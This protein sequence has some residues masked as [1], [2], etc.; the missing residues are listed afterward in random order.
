LPADARFCPACGG[1]LARTCARCGTANG[2]DH[3]FCKACGSA[4]GETPAPDAGAALTSRVSLEGERKQITVLFAD[5]KGSMELLASRDPEDARAVLDPVLEGMI[6][7]VRRYGGTVNQVMGDGVMALFGAPLAVEDHAVRAC[8]AALAMQDAVRRLAEARRSAGL[9]PPAIRVGL[10]S[11]EVLVRS[12]GSDV[13]VDYTAVGETTHLAARMEQTATPDAILL[14]QATY[15]LAEGFVDAKPLGLVGI[16]GLAEPVET[17]QLLGAHGVRTRLEARG[18]ALSRF[19]GREA[20]T[21]QAVRALAA[22]AAGRG[23]IVAVV[24]EPGVGKSRICHE[25]ARG[26]AGRGQRVVES[27]CLSYGTQTA[28]LPMAGLLET[29][30]DLDPRGE[31]GTRRAQAVERL[32]AID[33]ALGAAPAPILVLLG[34]PTSDAA[35]AA[36][37]PPLRRQQTLDALRQLILQ[38]ARSRPLIVVL[39]D[40][41]WV[42]AETQALLDALVDRMAAVPLALL[43]NY[44][45][46]YRHG[47]SG[48]S[49]YAQLRLDPLP[50]D[51][52]GALLE[53]LLGRDPSLAPLASLLRERTGGNPLFLE[54]SVRSLVETGALRGTAGDYR[55][56]RP[57]PS[58]E[59]PASVQ[60][61]LAARIDR[62]APQDK[63][64]LQCAAAIGYEV[65]L[66]LLRAIAGV[67]ET[68]LRDGLARLQAGELVY[69]TR[70][71]PDVEYTF[72]HALTHDVAYGSLLREQRRTLHA[73]IA[74]ALEAGAAEEH[75]AALAHHAGLGEDWPR[76]ARWARVAADQAAALCADAESV[77]LYEQALTAL[78]RLPETAETARAGLDVRFAL[79]APLWRAGRLDRLAPLFREVESLATRHGQTDRLDAVAA[80]LTQ[81]YWASGDYRK[82]IEYGERSLAL[83]ER[84]DDLALRASTHF[85]LGHSWRSMGRLPDGRA[86]YARVYALLEGRETERCG[87]SGLPFSGSCAY[88]AWSALELGDGAEALELI[89]R[90]ARVADR[91]GHLYSQIVI[92]IYRAWVLMLLGRADEARPVAEAALA[93]CRER[94]FAGQTMIALMALG[95]TLG[96]LGRAAEGVPLVEECI[97]LQQRANAQSDRGLMLCCLARLRLASGDLDGAQRAL[98]EGR[99]FVESNPEESY[100]AWQDWVRGQLAA[101][102]GDRAGAVALWRR[103]IAD[104]E[105]LGLALLRAHCRLSLGLAHRDAGDKDAAR[106]ELTQA[107]TAF[108]TIG[109]APRA[110][111]ADTALRGL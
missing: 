76:A 84:R 59:V 96:E 72:K 50:P 108:R 85:Y 21:A 20:E 34:L 49:Y 73:T 66:P 24:G 17:W 71:Y 19:V 37:D 12:I 94:N 78:A 33:P 11:G 82:S 22:A 9:P 8:Y 88:D 18:S 103:A 101:A 107:A 90:G 31:A 105:R 7:A 36:L 89:E 102:R 28:Y 81:F 4:L 16:K 26:A 64:L 54:E 32:R 86:H 42:D 67:D 3:R 38:A 25:L 51:T 92:T 65:P 35:W 79:R 111:E 44:R 74:A 60:A 13:N 56:A 41:Q 47:W 48:K 77:A 1:A 91:A 83:A 80:F 58:M 2:P 39:E 110:T 45:P 52:V 53:A 40:L 99:T 43:V 68:A 109:A 10:N 98:D 30:L 6:E 27:A 95:L 57:V 14:T 15:R 97:A 29:L 23:Q 69:E 106:R 61:V 70:L 75:A 63:R 104:G 100:G 55:L 46:E 87:L 5:L 93:T 62:L